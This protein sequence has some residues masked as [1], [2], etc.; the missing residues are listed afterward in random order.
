MQISGL[1]GRVDTDSDHPARTRVQIPGVPHSSLPFSNST[2]HDVIVR[3]SKSLMG[4]ATIDSSL[5][6]SNHYSREHSTVEVFVWVGG[7]SNT[8]IFCNSSI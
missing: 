2:G 5:P 3:F 4:Y 7:T 8:S 1:G 6:I